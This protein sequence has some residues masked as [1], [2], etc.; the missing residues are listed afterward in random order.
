MNL[1]NITLEKKHIQTYLLETIK[2]REK[3]TYATI[4]K[5]SIESIIIVNTG[6]DYDHVTLHLRSGNE[7]IIYI[8]LDKFADIME[9]FT[10]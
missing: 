9:W 7:I 8:E 10:T 1:H 6:Y 4:P 3:A 2:G 5:K